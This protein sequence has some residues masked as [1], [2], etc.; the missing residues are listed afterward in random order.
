[1]LLNLHVKN[2]AL[3][4]EV[5]IDFGK[6]LVVITGETGAGKSLVLGSVNIAL[7]NKVNKDIIR[8]GKEFALVELTFLA[9]EKV[10]D[11]LEEYDINTE[12]N[13]VTVSRKITDTRSISKINGETV[14][15]TILKDIMSHL[16]DIHGQHDHQSL[17][18]KSK[19]LEI[20][21]KYAGEEMTDV[22]TELSCSYREYNGLIK[23]VDEFNLDENEKLR[24]LE[25][26]QYEVNEIDDAELINGEDDQLENQ[27]KKVSNG[28]S[29]VENLS[30]I[31]AIFND[32]DGLK[33][34]I[35][36]CIQLI[37]EV[38][39]EEV[40]G[41]RDE[42]YNIEA[43]LTDTSREVYSQVE[44]FTFNPEELALIEKR[45][46]SINHLK[47]KYGKTIDDILRYRDEKQSRIDELNNYDANYQKVK[48]S[49]ENKKKEIIRFC[50]KASSIRKKAAI[51]LQNKVTQALLDLNFLQ[52][53]FHISVDEKDD[54]NDKGYN[55]VEFLISTNPGEA[56]RPLGKVA[57]GGEL[58][59]IML[60][61]KSIL[62]NEDDVDTL[63]FDEIDTGIS[64]K[65]ASMVAEKLNV[66]SRSRQVICI[67]HL[68]QIAAMADNHYLIEKN[69]QDNETFT[70]ISKLDYDKS[71]EELVRI[72]GG[73]KDSGSAV[74]LAKEMKEMA[75][76]TKNSL[77]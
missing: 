17:L 35:T 54:F 3:I 14:N 33:D 43:L 15:V 57:S 36:K 16:I 29:I 13:I 70:N 9:D 30:N 73:S 67:S 61:L 49:I 11:K 31:D 12:D 25:F 20:L 7:G 75:D 62:A 65:T 27:Y 19:H 48:D 77:F 51:S 37:N 46:D 10:I 34:L 71:I 64:G 4:D 5:D 23:K 1:M 58:S 69:I 26:A 59:R 72:S 60:A 28:K 44:S 2:L 32:N 22:L 18:Y 74:S 76:K 39:A 8:N 40:D 6:G 50:E 42:L 56:A 63:I 45:L 66:I 38:D 47:L 21:D 41:I 68:A 53:D 55:E 52:V 24:E